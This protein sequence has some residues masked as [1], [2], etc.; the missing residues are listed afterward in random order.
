MQQSENLID[1][2]ESNLSPFIRKM[3]R[4]INKVFTRRLKDFKQRDQTSIIYWGYLLKHLGDFVIRRLTASRKT[5]KKDYHRIA[6]NFDDI[7][8]FFMHF[9]TGTRISI[10]DEKPWIARLNQF[11]KDSKTALSAKIAMCISQIHN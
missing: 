6:R 8:L 3:L 4:T 2:I 5:N 10:K 7:L 11:I 9:A 1:I